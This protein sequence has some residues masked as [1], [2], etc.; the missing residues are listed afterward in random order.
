[1]AIK[2]RIEAIGFECVECRVIGRPMAYF[3]GLG[4][5]VSGA[6]LNETDGVSWPMAF[7]LTAEEQ[8]QLVDFVA[9]IEQRFEAQ[10][11]DAK[12]P[13]EL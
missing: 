10:N 4:P 2:A 12:L 8:Q 11:K 5:V 7:R 13:G 3:P 9:V 1:M 6:V